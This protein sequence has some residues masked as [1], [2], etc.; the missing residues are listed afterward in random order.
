[1]SEFC[2]QRIQFCGAAKEMS[3]D[4]MSLFAVYVNRILVS[5]E[6]CIFHLGV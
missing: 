5:E 3:N 1:M 2:W 4:Q 6:E